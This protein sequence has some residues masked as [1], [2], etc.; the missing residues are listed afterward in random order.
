MKGRL[1]VVIFFVHTGL[2]FIFD[3]NTGMVKVIRK[4]K[5]QTLHE[6]LIE[7]LN[8]ATNPMPKRKWSKFFG[9]V[10]FGGSPVAY[11]RKLRD[12]AQ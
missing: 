6:Q 10:H 12:E 7:V 8:T 5:T 4:S 1:D 9:K 2:C 3:K 11:Q